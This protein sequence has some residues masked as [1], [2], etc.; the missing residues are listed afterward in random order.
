MRKG[1]GQDTIEPA[2]DRHA[3]IGDPAL[4]EA[5]GG[6]TAGLAVGELDPDR[7][8]RAQSGSSCP[9]QALAI[10]VR[11]ASARSATRWATS[12]EGASTAKL[13]ERNEAPARKGRIPSPATRTAQVAAQARIRRAS[14]LQA[15]PGLIVP[16]PPGRNSIKTPLLSPRFSRWRSDCRSVLER[17]IARISV[18]ASGSD[19]PFVRCDRWR[20]AIVSGLADPRRPFYPILRQVGSGIGKWSCFPP[21][22]ATFRNSGH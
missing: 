9:S 4:I 20:L 14:M 13:V 8:R 10:A 1:G 18:L 21:E 7:A 11:Q 3:L 22:P 15:P 12:R 2:L 17:A 6:Q 16:V 5:K 19:Y